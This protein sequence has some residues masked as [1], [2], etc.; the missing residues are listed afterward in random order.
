MHAAICVKEGGSISNFRSKEGQLKHGE[1][2][3]YCSSTRVMKDSSRV[4]EAFTSAVHKKGPAKLSY[5]F[6]TAGP[7]SQAALGR[8]PDLSSLG[9]LQKCGK[10]ISGSVLYISQIFMSVICSDRQ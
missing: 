7:V 4:R 6:I 10:N 1:V 2:I 9:F 8:F 5:A 3:I